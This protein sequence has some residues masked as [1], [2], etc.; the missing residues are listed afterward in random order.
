MKE[1]FVITIGRQLGSGGKAVGERL[2]EAF[3]IPVYD[4]RLI[5][6]AAQQSGL[7]QEFFEQADE[8]GSSKGMLTTLLGYLRSPFTGGDALYDNCLHRDSL[9]KVQSD[10]IRDLSGRES[11][12][13]VGRCADYILRDNP[14]CV[15]LFVTADRS[16]RIARLSRLH[17]IA[18]H[19][20][21][22]M[23]VEADR[24][25]SDY[26]NYYS[27]RTWG[28]ADTYHLCINSSVLGIDATAEFVR[29][30][31][32]QRFPDLA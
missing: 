25:R 1:K 18:P 17:G 32:L 9:F 28:A 8:K 15:N 2:S 7:G 31:I 20:A 14:R 26:Y 16:D 5:K 29:R 22:T 27:N 10:V 3:G 24:K 30:F 13:F 23:I 6:F 19:E 21:E 4:K 12:I 11:C